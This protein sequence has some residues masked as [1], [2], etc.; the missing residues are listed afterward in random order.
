VRVYLHSS[1]WALLTMVLTLV[2]LFLP[3]LV[4]TYGFTDDY[5]LLWMGSGGGPN[6]AFGKTIATA[7]AAGGRPV[8][9]LP[10]AALFS[11]AGTIENLQ[12]IRGLSVL[13]ILAVAVLLHWRLVKAGLRA[14]P[15][16]LISVLMC[17]LPSFQVY[18]FWATCFFAPYAALLG[19]GASI[20]AASAASSTDRRKAA[21]FLA[22]VALLLAAVLTY[23]PTA[24]FF[25][26]LLAVAL[27]GA[28]EEP[29][30]AARVVRAHLAVA[31]VAFALA[32]LVLRV[33]TR[34]IGHD[35]PG[36]VA[37]SGF[38][39]QPLIKA[40]WFVFVPFRDALS[41]TRLSGTTG[42][43]WVAALV[44]ILVV[45]A[46]LHWRVGGP[47]G[48][49]RYV[50]LAAALI[51]LSYLPNLVVRENWASFRTEGS[52]GPL[53]AL[54][55]CLGAAGIWSMVRESLAPRISGQALITLDRMLVGA[56]TLLVAAGVFAASDSLRRLLVEPQVVELRQLRGEVAALPSHVRRVAFV[57][58]AP[59]RALYEFGEPSSSRS[60]PLAASV[61][62]IL[63]EDGRLGARPP[64]VDVVPPGS[65][66]RRREPVIDLGTP[67]VVG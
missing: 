11:A 52:L 15:A 64:V 32:F 14:G 56:A 43:Q 53:L 17:S 5:S 33:L 58:S 54:Y 62:L 42:S 65:Q 44:G 45:A 46:I 27:I 10:A 25:W 2:G 6:P 3:V 63:R 50:V 20:L 67:R 41:L 4:R 47:T 34:L 29:R 19:A 21:L 51:P 30:R 66:P 36:S 9:S 49:R 28:R 7:I 1:R 31:G 35:A 38:T 40:L 12:F 59:R 26:V 39:H 57:M 60:W 23:Q 37:R 22:A 18:A 8:A 24:M 16:A 48:S 13:G 55:A 61:N